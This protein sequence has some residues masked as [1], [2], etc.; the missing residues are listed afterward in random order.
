M[1]KIENIPKNGV[2]ILTV[3]FEGYKD[4]FQN[5]ARRYLL[6]SL[7]KKDV[8]EQMNLTPLEFSIVRMI[9]GGIS[10]AI[11]VTYQF[12]YNNMTPEK[13]VSFYDL[14]DREAKNKSWWDRHSVLIAD[15]V[16]GLEDV[17]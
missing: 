8:V 13:F 3:Y 11:G 7:P 6:D 5:D 16:G 4:S 10:R 15:Y 9:V 12:T 17:E 1:I 2:L 14:L